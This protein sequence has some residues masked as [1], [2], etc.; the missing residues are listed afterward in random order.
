MLNHKVL[1]NIVACAMLSFA[2]MLPAQGIDFL[3]STTDEQHISDTFSGTFAVQVG[4]SGTCASGH[5]CG[6]ACGVSG[7]C[8][9]GAFAELDATVAGMDTLSS[10][11]YGYALLGSAYTYSYW[12]STCS[13]MNFTGGANF[14]LGC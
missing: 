2:A 13:G 7:D 12:I 1:K 4:I 11:C 8:F 3:V 5:T 9:V 6:T 10:Q 14:G